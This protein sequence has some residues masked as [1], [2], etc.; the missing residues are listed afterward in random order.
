[1][2]WRPSVKLSVLREIGWNHWDPIRLNGSEGGWQRSNAADEYDRY[3][4]RVARGLQSGEADQ[5]LVDYLVG[6]E[7]TH[8]GLAE[9]P[10]LRSRAEAAVAALR[11][12]VESLTSR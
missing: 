3:M 4:L 7:T 1:M 8:M 11:E 12:E 5:T 9:T 10:T 6:I 2:S